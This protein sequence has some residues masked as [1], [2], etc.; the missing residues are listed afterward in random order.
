VE[1]W[2]EVLVVGLGAGSAEEVEEGWEEV[3]VS[4]VDLVVGS[5]EACLVLLV[6]DCLVD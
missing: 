2:A 3:S 1:D 5:V 6:V 4:P